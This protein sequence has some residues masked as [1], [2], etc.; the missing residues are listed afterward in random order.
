MVIIISAAILIAILKPEGFAVLL[1]IAVAAIFYIARKT[2]KQ[3]RS[4]VWNGTP[5]QTSNWN[6]RI[7]HCHTGALERQSRIVSVFTNKWYSIACEEFVVVDIETTGLDR[8][9]DHIIELSAIRFEGGVEQEKFTTLIRPPVKIPSDAVAVHGITNSAVRSAPSIDSVLPAFL[10]FVGDS[11]LVGH[12]ANFDIA[13]IEIAAREMGYNPAWRYIDTISV[14][15]KAYPGLPNYKQQTILRTM[16]YRQPNAHRA[17]D[18]ARGC[19]QILTQTL[20]RIADG[21]SF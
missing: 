15:K 14:A 2:R 7:R 5:A 8:Y 16:G 4:G 13:F 12:N 17:E 18:D 6:E 1:I 19:A 3:N 10:E 21:E 20:L 11:L 9:Y